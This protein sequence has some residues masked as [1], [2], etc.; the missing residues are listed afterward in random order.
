MRGAGIV[1]DKLEMP[2][3]SKNDVINIRDGHASGPSVGFSGDGYIDR[4]A[5]TIDLRG[6]IAP[7]YGLNSVLGALPILG[8]MLVSKQGEG[9]IGI[10]YEA[11]GSLDEPKISVNPLSMLAP[12]IFR[13]IFEGRTPSAAPRANKTP[14]APTQTPH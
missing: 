14:T 13:R 1:V 11:S 10:T 4:R 3:S 6:A 7:I 8:N 2:F 12:G 9:I 5:N